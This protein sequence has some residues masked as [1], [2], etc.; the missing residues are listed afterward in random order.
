[1]KE[2]EIVEIGKYKVKI[3]KQLSEGGFGFIY[4]V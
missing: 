2:N 3:I 4:V 1:M